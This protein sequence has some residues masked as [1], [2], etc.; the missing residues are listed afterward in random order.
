MINKF[1]NLIITAGAL[2]ALAL[3]AL[4]DTGKESFGVTNAVLTGT[5]TNTALGQN[6]VS[7]RNYASC[8]LMVTGTL[9]ATNPAP[10]ITVD[11]ARKGSAGNVESLTRFPYTFTL[12]A[13]GADAGVSVTNA[14]VVMTNIVDTTIGA[15]SDL[16]LIDIKTVNTAGF[17]RSPTVTIDIKK[18]PL[19]F[20]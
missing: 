8:T 6:T 14:F 15:A 5:A 20:P 18:I 19:S 16:S 2:F 10:T 13:A 17:I 1:K 7:V 11:I 4:A 9:E 3:P 12:S